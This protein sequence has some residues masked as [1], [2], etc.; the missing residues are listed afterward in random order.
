MLDYQK[1]RVL[2]YVTRAE[3]A[4]DAKLEAAPSFSV[5]QS[6]K[7]QLNAIRSDVEAGT[8]PSQDIADRL[9]LSRYA[10]REFEDTDPGYS[11]LLA[12]AEYYYKHP[13][14]PPLPNVHSD[15]HS[16]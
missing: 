4:T 14:A 15:S 16:S 8:A 11:T 5:L 12:R 9:L 10:V 7:A 13:D 6:I 2:L 1:D 3:V